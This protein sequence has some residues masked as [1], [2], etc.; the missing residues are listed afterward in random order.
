MKTVNAPNERAF[1]VPFLSTYAYKNLEK[2][3]SSEPKIARRIREIY[4]KWKTID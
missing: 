4:L 3:V 1:K 2:R